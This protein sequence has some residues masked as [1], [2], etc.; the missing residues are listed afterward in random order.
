MWNSIVF[1]KV[2]V[3]CPPST[4]SWRIGLRNATDRGDQWPGCEPVRSVTGHSWV[5]VS[6]WRRA[7]LRAVFWSVLA[8]G[9]VAGS[10][11]LVLLVQYH[12]AVMFWVL[13]S[14]RLASSQR[15]PMTW[16]VC[17]PS[18]NRIRHGSSVRLV[19]DLLPARAMLVRGQFVHVIN[20]L[21]VK[22]ISHVK[23]QETQQAPRPLYAI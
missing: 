16:R 14:V 20:K 4:T 21:H 12:L 1:Q 17:V 22:P 5:D 9:F 13:N 6:F 3:G 18:L 23:D 8:V 10:R 15:L 11:R 19:H 7:L 2:S